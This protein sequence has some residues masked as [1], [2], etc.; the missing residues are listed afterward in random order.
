MQTDNVT[1]TGHVY[2]MCANATDQ[3]CV[4]TDYD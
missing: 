3:L 2:L 4:K 1:A